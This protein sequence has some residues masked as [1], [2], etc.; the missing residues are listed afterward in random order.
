MA[1]YKS[2]TANQFTQIP[3]ETLQDASLSFEAKGLLVLILSLPENWEIHKTWLQKQTP[4]CGQDKLKRILKE[5][6]DSG[7]MVKKPKKLENGRLSGW[8]WF[9]YPVKQLQANETSTSTVGVKTRSTVSSFD[10]GP[11]TTNKHIN[12]QTKT[13]TTDKQ[14]F[15]VFAFI[16][17]SLIQEMLSEGGWIPTGHPVPKAT[18]LKAKAKSLHEKLPDP[19]PEDCAVIILRDW[20]NLTNMKKVSF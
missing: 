12:K 4:K 15:D 7:Y 14:E 19:R 6:S 11:A 13:T 17:L 1:I 2:D 16:L 9:V 10:G 5:I 18:W 3:N 8:D 20:V